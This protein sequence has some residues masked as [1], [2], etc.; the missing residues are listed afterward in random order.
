MNNKRPTIVFFYGPTKPL[1][2]LIRQAR[3]GHTVLAN[4][5]RRKPFNPNHIIFFSDDKFLIRIKRQK[6]RT[7][8]TSVLTLRMSLLLYTPKTG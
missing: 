1:A 6:A 3:T 7:P 8:A 5:T 2:S 4:S